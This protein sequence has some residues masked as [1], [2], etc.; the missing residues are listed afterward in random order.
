MADDVLLR[1]L[2]A[3]VT[4]LMATTDQVLDMV[5]ALAAAAAASA[6]VSSQQTDLLT[7]IAAGQAT[8]DE[9]ALDL[10]RIRE[11]LELLAG[12]VAG[13]EGEASSDGPD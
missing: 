12:Q 4:K 2:L 11:T 3:L 6:T 1:Q 5:T 7:T 13:D 9:M 10:S 8:Q